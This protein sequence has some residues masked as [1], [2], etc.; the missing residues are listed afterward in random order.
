MQG[1]KARIFIIVFSILLTNTMAVGQS[2][3]IPNS[4]WGISFGNSQQF[5]GLRFNAIDQHVSQVDGVNITFWAA[6]ENEIAVVN[7]LALGLIPE[8]G[9]LRGFNMGLAGVIAHKELTGLSFAVL[10]AGSGG[11]VN[12]IAFGGLG[13]GAG[14]DI[15]GIAF[16]GLGA[17][18]GGDINGLA[19]GGLGAGA[20]KSLN[21]AVIGG[22]GGGASHSINGFALG[23]LGAGAG[24]SFN[25][26]GLGGL[27]VG[28]GH[29]ATGIFFGGLGSGAGHDLTG[30]AI[31]GLG[32]GAGHTL[33]GLSLSLGVAMATDFRGATLAGGSVWTE[34]NGSHIGFSLSAFNY[35]RGK[36]T[37]L[38]L[39]VVN[40]AVEL[41]GVQLG[42]VNYVAENPMLFRIM[43]LINFNW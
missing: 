43:P 32:N 2:L 8:A 26:V 36:M 19:F 3:D 22:L 27:G 33:T 6:R 23:F 38:S 34:E 35:I 7:G 20:G 42:L 5:S 25:G 10:G 40:Y 18:A 11:N 41:N 28:A 30:M 37:G 15:D 9:T 13:A 4:K 12:G 21:G 17:G 14:A 39:G 24:H 29:S 31:A 16:G 1:Q